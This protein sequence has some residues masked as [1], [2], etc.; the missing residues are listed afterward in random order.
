MKSNLLIVG[1]Q[2]KN[3][4]DSL[5]LPKDTQNILLINIHIDNRLLA[6]SFN[7]THFHINIMEPKRNIYII[8]CLYN[9][10]Y[11]NLHNNWKN[12]RNTEYT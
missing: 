12:K 5:D 6:I 3:L 2:R 4:K 11:G 7:I 9:Y 8:I 1:T 10:S